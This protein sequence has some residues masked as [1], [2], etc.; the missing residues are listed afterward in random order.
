[1]Q[2]C[3]TAKG[4]TVLHLGRSDSLCDHRWLS[5]LTSD[6]KYS[7]NNPKCEMGMNSHSDAQKYLETICFVEFFEEWRVEGRSDVMDAVRWP[8]RLCIHCLGAFTIP[9]GHQVKHLTWL[10]SAVEWWMHMMRI[11][12]GPRGYLQFYR[13]NLQQTRSLRTYS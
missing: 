8:G 4:V 11:H 6:P 13:K 12:L 5:G 3:R 2:Y 7:S 9:C 10:T 1:M